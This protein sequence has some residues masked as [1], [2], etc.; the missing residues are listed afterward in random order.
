[1]GVSM[2]HKHLSWLQESN[3][4]EDPCSSTLGGFY[5]EYPSLNFEMVSLEVMNNFKAIV[6]KEVSTSNPLLV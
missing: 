3:N 4:F 5:N 2:N 1:M 6:K